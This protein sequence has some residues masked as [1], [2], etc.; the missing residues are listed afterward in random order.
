MGE[1]DWSGITAVKEE[2]VFKYPFGMH[3]WWPPCTDT[4]LAMWWSAKT[5]YPELFT[6]VDMDAM[7][8]EYYQKWYG[9][10]LTDEDVAN[11]LTAPA[12]TYRHY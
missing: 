9:M 12:Q 5:A 6:D 11:I 8:K 10:E 2:Q 7:V 3:R 1:D 4:P